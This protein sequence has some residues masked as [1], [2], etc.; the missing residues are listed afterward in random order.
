M[1][2][3]CLLLLSIVRLWSYMTSEGKE[4]LHPYL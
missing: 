4:R 3:D 2:S 1:Q